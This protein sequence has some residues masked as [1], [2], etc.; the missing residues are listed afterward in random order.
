MTSITSGTEEEK[1]EWMFNMYD[2]DGNKTLDREEIHSLVNGLIKANND[3]DK[4][5]EEIKQMATNFFDEMDTDKN[6]NVDLKEFLTVSLKTPLIKDSLTCVM[7]QS[8][9]GKK[10]GKKVLI[11]HLI[12]INKFKYS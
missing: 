4:T 8:L 9:E 1:L 12:L 5:N 3:Q 11:F 10:Y 7:T 6:G 2:A